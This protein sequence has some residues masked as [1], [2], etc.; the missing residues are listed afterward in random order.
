MNKHVLIIL[1]E[2]F[3]EMEAV[4]PA[5]M[6]RRAGLNVTIAALGKELL[7]NGSRGVRIKADI[8]LEGITFV[9]DALVLPGGGK[10]AE[11]LA[12]SE[13]VIEL[14][15]QTAQMGK[16]VAAI[17]ASPAHALVKAGVLE[18]KTATCY[19]G[20]EV[21][22]KGNTVYKKDNVVVDSNIITSRG[23]GTAFDFALN[24]I[25]ALGGKP[26]AQQVKEKALIA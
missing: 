7:V 1:A 21:F 11:N 9:P 15:K 10:G 20:E 17:C 24:I 8:M 18:G 2:G 25:E 26:L 16:T 5:D 19:P 23:P 22:F 6:L 4:I 14:V 3:E 13:K 12:S